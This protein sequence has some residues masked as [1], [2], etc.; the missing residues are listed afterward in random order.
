MTKFQSIQ[1][2]FLHE[3]RPLNRLNGKTT[4]HPFACIAVGFD[5]S[6]ADI[7]FRIAVSLCHP[8]DNM[9]RRVGAQKAEGLL[10]AGCDGT[11]AHVKWFKPS[12]AKNLG[13]ILT[14]LGVSSKLDQRIVQLTR[15]NKTFKMVMADV[16]GL[17]IF[18]AK[19]K[20]ATVGACKTAK[21]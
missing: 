5:P 14:A 7:P 3:K 13:S 12:E 19:P 18:K 9:I 21:A 17:R 10:Q 11:H 2:F 16:Q 15:G 4:S 20:K 8:K 1:H 6:I